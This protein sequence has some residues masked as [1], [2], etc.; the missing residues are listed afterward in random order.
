M[1]KYRCTIRR[2]VDG[3]T[4]DIDLDLGFDIILKDQRVRLYGIDAPES[5]TRDLVE[6]E[7]GLA[8]KKRLEELLSMGKVFL[9]S[10]EY[11]SRGK[12]GRILGDFMVGES[13]STVCEQL[14]NEGYVAPYFG[15]DKEQIKEQHFRNRVKLI[16]EG[17]VLVSNYTP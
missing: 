4:V 13:E 10:K 1:Y 17:K 5:R 8:A 16:T 3:D 9:V 2:V 7:F 11:D 15:G 14:I 12:F 6:K